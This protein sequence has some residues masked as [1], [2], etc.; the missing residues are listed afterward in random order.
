MSN[1]PQPPTPE[2]QPQ[3]NS[4]YQNQCTSFWPWLYILSL[5]LSLSLYIDIHVYVY[6]Y[7]KLFLYLTG[8]LFLH[9]RPTTLCAGIRPV[10]HVWGVSLSL[11]PS[12]AARSACS[13][14]ATRRQHLS[15]SMLKKH[16]PETQDSTERTRSEK[17]C[18]RDTFFKKIY[19]CFTNLHMFPLPSWTPTFFLAAHTPSSTD[20]WYELEIYY[21]ILLLFQAQA[22]LRWSYS[23]LLAFLHFHRLAITSRLS[24]HGLL[25][26][27]STHQ[28]C[29]QPFIAHLKR[30]TRA[31]G[32][33]SSLRLLA[34][35]RWILP[36]DKHSV[37]RDRL[38]FHSISDCFN[39]VQSQIYV[40]CLVF[41]EV[42]SERGFIE[43]AS[44]APQTPTRSKSDL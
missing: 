7:S 29:S 18:R 38:T 35:Y 34:Q 17:R 28:K 10:Q 19:K 36:V 1:S 32:S 26:A 31:V 22:Q 43:T 5:S 8:V 3:P 4:E 41:P 21:R 37:D 27:T 30:W 9:I 2:D 6:I 16:K 20:Y 33:R 44:V 11:F 40:F 13:T 39:V 15:V 24:Q 14:P 12:P 42:N 25:T 23:S